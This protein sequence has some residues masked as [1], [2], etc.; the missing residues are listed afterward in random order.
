MRFLRSLL[1]LSC[2]LAVLELWPLQTA[3]ADT[4]APPQTI[5]IAAGPFIEGSDRAEREAAYVLDEKAYAH[6]ATRRGRWYEGEAPRRQASRPAFAITK[7]LITNA[8]YA[9]FVK[10]TGHRAPNVDAATWA[11]YGLKHP[12]VRTMKYSWNGPKPPA[13]R[14]DHPVVLVSHGDARAYAKWLSTKTGQIWRLPEQ[15]QW[16]KAARGTDG[17]RFPWGNDFD[18]T[19]LNSHDQGPFGTTA[20]GSFPNGASPYGMLDAGGQ[21]FEWTRDGVGKGR[22]IVKGGSWDDKGCGICRPAARHS[23]P[24]D[25]KHILIGFRLVREIIE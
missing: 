4:F 17:R 2:V 10:E 24:G 12:F 5:L 6:S 14:G 21:V 15:G 22:F 18:P 8:A 23:R 20:V 11:G 19:R 13:G 3:W 1:S 9:V 7:N 16:E 25:I